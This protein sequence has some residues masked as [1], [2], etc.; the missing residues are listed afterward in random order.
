MRTTARIAGTLLIVLAPRTAA[1]HDGRPLEPHD[2]ARAW[3][4]EPWA[5][6]VL[7]AS[8]GVYVLGARRIARRRTHGPGGRR[9]RTL[10]FF[11]GWTVLALALLSPIHALGSVLLSAHMV[12][13]EVLMAVATPLLVLGR[14]LVP[15]LWATSPGSRHWLGRVAR[16]PAIRAAWRAATRPFAAA[17]IHGA[18]IWI[19]HARPLYEAGL[20]SD[21]MHSIQHIAFIATALLFWWSIFHARRARSGE[22]V[23]ALFLTALHT[24]ALGALL[25]FAGSLWYPAYAATTGPWGLS[26]LEDQQL[27]GLIMWIPGGTVYLIVALAVAARWVSTPP[28]AS[29]RGLVAAG[30]MCLTTLG[31][32]CRAGLDDDHPLRVP[33]VSA[34]RGTIPVG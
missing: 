6:V 5:I 33:E 9:G 25:T 30:A 21:A 3:S 29:S 26:P 8:L 19:W 2:L 32:G 27:A 23:L 31:V 10:A 17:L 7:V 28:R 11:A 14:P 13:H 24:G 12:Q 15:A 4:A 1:A 20:R 18:A 22:V 34:E 16:H